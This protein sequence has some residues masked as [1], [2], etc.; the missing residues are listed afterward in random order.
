MYKYYSNFERGKGGFVSQT[1]EVAEL[2][3]PGAYTSD[4]DELP[5]YWNGCVKSPFQTFGDL[6]NYLDQEALRMKR[7]EKLNKLL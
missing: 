7:N 1:K 3:I 6:L 4:E 2:T 5:F